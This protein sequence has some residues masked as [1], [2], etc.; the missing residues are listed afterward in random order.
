[1]RAEE[2]AMRIIMDARRKAEQ[3]DAEGGEQ[4]RKYREQT[5]RLVL[6]RQQRELRKVRQAEQESLARRTAQAER[7]A[8]LSL[9]A[10]KQKL[11]EKVFTDAAE[12]LRNLTGQER[13]SLLESLWKRTTSIGVTYVTAAERDAPSLAKRTTVKETCA[14]DGGFI[15]FG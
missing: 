4:V 15:A 5:R 6:Q 14:S 2:L 11:L 9:A 8:R 1:M 7:K 10:V 12:R 3:I 13:E